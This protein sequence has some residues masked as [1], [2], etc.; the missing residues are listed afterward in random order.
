MAYSV[1]DSSDNIVLRDGKELFGSYAITKGVDLEKRTLSIR[2]SDETRDRDGDIITVNGW[3]VENYLKNPVF[4]WAH[5]YTSVPLAATRKLVKKKVP[6]PHLE[7]RDVTFPPK[8]VH[9]FADMIL[10]LYGLKIINACSVGFVPMEWEKIEDDD[11]ETKAG[12]SNRRFTKQELLELSGCGVPSNPNALQDAIRGKHYGSI[13]PVDLIRGLTDGIP[14]IDGDEGTKDDIL[15][16]IYS[17]SC[18]YEEED[19]DTM[20]QV[21]QEYESV[22]TKEDVLKPYPNEHACRLRDPSGYSD[23]RRGTR[24]HDGKKYSIIFGKKD[25]SWE[26]QAY[27][28]SKDTWSASQARKHCKDHEGIAFEPSSETDSLEEVLLL[29][30]MVFGLEKRL[31]E[32][33]KSINDTGTMDC[34]DDVKKDSVEDLQGFSETSQTIYD[35]A[36]SPCDNESGYKGVNRDKRAIKELTESLK[37]LM[38]VLKK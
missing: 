33:Q 27:R 20:I 16:E 35:I 34:G 7:F 3:V 1:K 30:D 25:D 37:E 5:N 29:S 12:W 36:L 21:P 22:E 13:S 19:R 24:E 26:E 28:Y 10:E 6:F 4:L 31:D 8:G 23:F 14:I 9:P 17:V 2:G 11:N 15:E 32:I 18:S 38:E